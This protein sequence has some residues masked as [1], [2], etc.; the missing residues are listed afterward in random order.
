MMPNLDKLAQISG[1][2]VANIGSGIERRG[3]AATGRRLDAVLEGAA[4]TPC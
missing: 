4:P 1:D 2:K 3:L